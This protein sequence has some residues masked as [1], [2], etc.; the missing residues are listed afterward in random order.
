[1]SAKI[2]PAGN[3]HSIFERGV[4][5]LINN[6]FP[7]ILTLLR[8]EQGFSQ[9]KVAEDLGISQALLSHYEKG[10]RECGLNFVVKV[11]D[12]YGVS[13]DYLLGRTPHRTGKKFT[14]NE[15]PDDSPARAKKNDSTQLEYNR[16][17]L[18][19]SLNIVFAIL[20][21]IKSE[22]LTNV[23]SHYLFSAVYKAFRVLYS[24]NPKNPQGMFELDRRLFGA[25]IES[26]MAVS[27][28][29]ERYI[30]SGE[31]I[32]ECRGVSRDSLPHLTPELL[33]NDYPLYAPSLFD[34]IKKLETDVKS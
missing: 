7:R 28:A 15:V 25:T 12:Y 2:L 16:R 31:D 9:K 24:S 8:K 34:M 32:G 17:I 10:I 19:N 18:V 29:K 1:M 22:S 33:A 14:L 13:C 4:L 20:R 5:A 27:E 30:L 23:V 6:D 21:K 11:A 26:S 3:T